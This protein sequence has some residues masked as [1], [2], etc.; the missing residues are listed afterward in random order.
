MFDIGFS[1]LLLIAVLA[2]VVLG[3]KRLPEV[4]RTAGRWAG[5]ARRFVDSVKR[6]MDREMDD[7]GLAAL[8]DAHRSIKEAG[9]EMT[10]SVQ[11]SAAAVEYEIIEP[12]L[13]T[14]TSQPAIGQ[15][16]PEHAPAATQTAVFP[17]D[18]KD[19]GAPVG[20]AESTDPGPH[21][22]KN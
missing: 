14:K 4:A 8:R 5:R 19:P 20:G 6:D 13:E 21:A 16:S 22:E 7:E 15:P 3:P 17:N 18:A 1:E 2:L 9:A 11:A 10:R 12:Q